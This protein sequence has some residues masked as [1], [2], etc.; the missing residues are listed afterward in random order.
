MAATTSMTVY[1]LTKGT[2]S[3]SEATASLVAAAAELAIPFADADG[4]ILHV[5]N[6]DAAADA[7]V[8]IEANGDGPKAAL[9][10][11]VVTVDFGDEA[12][13]MIKDTGRFVVQDADDDDEGSIIVKLNDSA[14]DALGAAVLSDITIWAT[15]F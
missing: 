13:I 12:K 8:T 1:D 9:G 14:G 4:A 10:D 15:K 2:A 7:Y 11:Q 3:D 5:K 6:A